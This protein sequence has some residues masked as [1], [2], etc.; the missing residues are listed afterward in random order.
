MLRRWRET[1]R[2]VSRIVARAAGRGFGVAVPA[3]AFPAA[4]GGALQLGMKLLEHAGGVLAARHAEIEPLFGLVENRVGVVLAVVAA[5]AAI[6]LRH[7]RHH[8]A[9]QRLAV[10]ELHAIGERH[11][12]VVP[13]RAVVVVGGRPN[14][15]PGTSCAASSADSGVTPSQAEQAGEQAVQPGALL[16][17]ERRVLRQEIGIGGRGVMLMHASASTIVL[18]ASISWR[19]AKARKLSSREARCAR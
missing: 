5:L 13:R 19:R 2:G 17:R 18:S 9:R 7:R 4:G 15:T 14:A 11:R 6:L 12:R 16:R 8:A 10:G 3:R 1:K